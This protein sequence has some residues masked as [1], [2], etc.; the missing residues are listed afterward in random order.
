MNNN[1]RRYIAPELEVL[2]IKVERGYDASFTIG[3]WEDGDSES[4]DAE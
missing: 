3:G 2:A 4:G 1:E